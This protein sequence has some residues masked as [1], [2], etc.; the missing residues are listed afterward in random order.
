ML[1]PIHIIL[2]LGNAYMYMYETIARIVLDLLSKARTHI[3]FKRKIITLMATKICLLTL[4]ERTICHPYNL[5]HKLSEHLE[6]T[7]I[8]ITVNRILPQNIELNN[9]NVNQTVA[10]IWRRQVSLRA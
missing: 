3:A 6:C 9:K 8:S 1:S 5:Y 10:H 4:N 7:T 2:T